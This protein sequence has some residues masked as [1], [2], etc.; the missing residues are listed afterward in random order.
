MINN[1]LNILITSKFNLPP[2]HEKDV[3]KGRGIGF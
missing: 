1:G 3:K 2:K